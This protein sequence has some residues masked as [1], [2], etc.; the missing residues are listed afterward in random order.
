VGS[1]GTSLVPVAGAALDV[2]G[3]EAAVAVAVPDRLVGERVGLLVGGDDAPRPELLIDE[4][5]RVLPR[6]IVPAVVRVVTSLPLTTAGKI[7]RAR[8]REILLAAQEGGPT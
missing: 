7:N 2:A 4:L 8:A 3:V 6:T 5:A 1:L